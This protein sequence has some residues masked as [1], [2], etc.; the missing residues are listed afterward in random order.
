MEI[1]VLLFVFFSVLFGLANCFFGYPMFSTLVALWG[2]VLGLILGVAIGGQGSG[3]VVGIILGIVLGGIALA[4]TYVGIFFMGVGVGI[5]LTMT[6]LRALNMQPDTA[7]TI[8]IIVGLATG[9]LTI[10]LRKYVI[11]FLTAISGATGIVQGGLVLLPTTQFNPNTLEVVPANSSV[12]IVAVIA[13]FALAIL[14]MFYQWSQ[15]REEGFLE[16]LR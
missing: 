3:I 2:F 14:G 7:Q 11:I 10:L 5:V 6:V 15:A 12:A 1:G 13:G 4:M 8:A 9:A 16:S